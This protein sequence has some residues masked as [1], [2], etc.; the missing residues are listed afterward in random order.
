MPCTRAFQLQ[1]PL[2]PT[3]RWPGLDPG[4]CFS[5]RRCARRKHCPGSC[6]GRR[7]LMNWVR[8]LAPSSPGAAP[9]RAPIANT[10]LTPLIKVH[11]HFR[12]LTRKSRHPLAFLH[13]ATVLAKSFGGPRS[14]SAQARSLLSSRWVPTSRPPSTRSTFPSNA[15]TSSTRPPQSGLRS[16]LSPVHSTS[17]VMAVCTSSTRRAMCP[18]TSIFSSVHPQMEAGLS[19]RQTVRMI[20]GSLR[21]RLGWATT[22]NG[23]AYMKIRRRRRR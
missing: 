17:T 19:S 11:T 16:G 22:T 7:V 23:G 2:D 5:S 15:Q 12:K 14:S 8:S 20:G 1:N 21:A 13:K 6:P 3:L 10:A 18:A 4:P 9:H